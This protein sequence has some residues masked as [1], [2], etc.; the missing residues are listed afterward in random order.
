LTSFDDTSGWEDTIAEVIDEDR[1]PPWPANPAHGEFSND[2]RLT[3]KEKQIIHAW[4]DGG[5]PQ[6]EP[7]DLPSPPVFTDGWSIPMPDQVI[8][9]GTT[10]FKV[11]AEG[12]VDY[13]H[14]VV[15]PKWDTDKYI[16]AAQ[17]RPQNRAVVHHILVYLLPPGATRPDLRRVLVGF[18]PGSLPIALT[19]GVAIHVEAGTRLLFEM[20]YTPNGS[21]QSDLS[22]AGVCFMDAADVKK[23]W[24]GRLAINSKFRI[25]PGESHHE[26]FAM[27]QSQEDE[28]LISLTPH[29][30]LRGKSFRYD[31][32]NPDGTTEV[33]LDVPRYDFNWQLKYVLKTPKRLPKGAVVECKAVFDNSASNPS[34]P[35]PDREVGWG[36]QS[37][38]EMM[39]GFMDTVPAD[40]QP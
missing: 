26:T 39:I 40:P 19:D 36:D 21:A 20:H 7:N 10:A 33:L 1:M 23:H 14:F 2:A 25:P 11:P 13:Q 30:H 5:M 18:A 16:Y 31:L 22:D 17:A 29:M 34:N 27:Y 4:I 6:G 32:R 15:D 8:P 24:M 35:D 12:V 37:Y 28:M 9:M 38:D 3:I